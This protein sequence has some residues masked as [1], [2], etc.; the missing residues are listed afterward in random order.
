[1]LYIFDWDGTLCD[2]LSLITTSIRRSCE[3]LGLPV[4]SEEEN[5]SIIGLGLKEALEHLYPEIPDKQ[6][7]KLI[8]AYRDHY[9]AGDKSQPSQLYSGVQEVLDELRSQGHQLAV[10][11]G[12]SR[13][14]LDRVLGELKMHH[15][16]E[17]SRCADET[18]SKPHPLMLQ[19]ILQ[20]SGAHPRDAIMVGDTDF[21]LLMA[22]SASVQAIGVSYGAH[23]LDRIM[24]AEPHRIIDHISELLED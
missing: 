2:S 21:D 19:E 11:T 23:P 8:L 6:L 22:K 13:R 14:G 5:R 15:Y 7:D 1:M 9:L 18:R 12:K 17:H 24:Q 3:H 16:F 20:E 4:R 10:A